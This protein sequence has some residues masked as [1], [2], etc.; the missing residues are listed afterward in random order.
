[1]KIISSRKLIPIQHI[2]Y[3][4]FSYYCI[5]IFLLLETTT[6]FAGLID[7]LY[8]GT[9]KLQDG[10]LITYKLQLT[11]SEG[12]VK[13]YSI[14]DIN[15]DDETKATI[16][17]TVNSAGTQILFKEQNVVYTKSKSGEPD[18]C[19][20]QGSLKVKNYGGTRLL[21][22]HFEGY[23]N[24]G[25]S[26]C[27]NGK[28]ILIS[29]KDIFKILG[30][31]EESIDSAINENVAHNEPTEISLLQHKHKSN[32][33]NPKNSEPTK[34]T[35]TTIPEPDNKQ[36]DKP[37]SPNITFENIPKNIPVVLPQNSIELNCSQPLFTLE[38]WDN[39]TID[40]D[41]VTL[42]QGSNAIIKNYTLTANHLLIRIDL[43][44]KEK[45]VL[46]LI[47]VSEGS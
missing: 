7:T 13:G 19:L 42:M 24:G 8:I 2:K 36:N 35:R 29:P 30:K 18:F 3:F 38:I 1:M 21:R 14:M 23:V 44:N 22:G 5:L 11:D 43:G 15:G 46:R 6:A 31:S 32:P 41:I 47:A 20:L 10:R 12:S 34:D 16:S 37:Q 9:A 33:N 4:K 45:D 39:K 17:G 40:G 26:I 25:N 28:L 27:A